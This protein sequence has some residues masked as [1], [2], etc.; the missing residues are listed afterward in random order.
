MATIG[1]RADNIA[2]IGLGAGVQATFLESGQRLTYYEID[3]TVGVLASDPAL[4]T[5]FT[6]VLGHGRPGLWRRP[7]RLGGGSEISIS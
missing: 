1:R 6:A 3:P 4:F 2:V 5:Y 7:A